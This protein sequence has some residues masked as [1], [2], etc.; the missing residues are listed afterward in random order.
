MQRGVQAG[1]GLRRHLHAQAFFFSPFPGGDGQVMKSVKQK[2]NQSNLYFA[3]VISAAIGRKRGT[4][5]YKSRGDI[6]RQYIK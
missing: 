2:N 4:L 5:P 6:L 1:A 3:K